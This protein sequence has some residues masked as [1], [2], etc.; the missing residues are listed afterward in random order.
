MRRGIAVMVA[1]PLLLCWLGGNAAAEDS[2]EETSCPKTIGYW[3]NHIPWS[4]SSFSICATLTLTSEQAMDILNS[5][6]VGGTASITVA[7]QIIAT[8]L[9]REA[10]GPAY[11]DPTLE[12]AKAWSCG[13]PP[14]DSDPEDPDRQTGLD[15]KD[16]LDAYNQSGESGTCG[17]P[18]R[19]KTPTKTQTPTETLT[20]TSTASKTETQT[21]TPTQTSSTTQTPT[22][23]STVT[24]TN[25]AT[26]TSSATETATATAVPTD[27]P[28]TTRTSTT[29]PTS[30]PTTTNTVRNTPTSSPTATWTP[31]STS[32]VTPTR[33]SAGGHG[34]ATPTP[35]QRKPP[36]PVQAPTMSP[37]MLAA[38]VVM[39][40]A[41]G[42]WSI[43]RRLGQ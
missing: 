1:T 27:T 33:T 26:A 4:L 24:P 5:P 28:T 8:M 25:T 6:D 39:L 12:A 20:P 30:S 29:T 19:T 15:L 34:T 31:T 40:T 42:R 38:L 17:T 2:T 7:K 10:G 11:I 22:E 3:K 16:T 43:R 14:P 36:P 37:P 9:N 32:T 35:T 21:V 41:I 18:T 13:Y 23:S